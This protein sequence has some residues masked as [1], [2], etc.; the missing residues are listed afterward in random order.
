MLLILYYSYDIT[1][2]YAI[3]TTI[4]YSYFLYIQIYQR[5]IS[6]L[7]YMTES[8]LLRMALLSHFWH[9]CSLLQKK[10]YILV[11]KNSYLDPLIG[12]WQSLFKFASYYYS[13][14]LDFHY[15][16][17]DYIKRWL[18]ELFITI[19]IHIWERIRSQMPSDYIINRRR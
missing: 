11:D 19:Q 18:L 15:I 4:I 1:V 14:S 8:H 17:T 3:T 10:K 16:I 5:Y 13:H 2:V 6:Y 7:L 12:D 9:F